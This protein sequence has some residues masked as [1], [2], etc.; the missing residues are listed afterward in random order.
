METVLRCALVCEEEKL[1]DVMLFIVDVLQRQA[2]VA[3][4]PRGL[5]T[6]GY[7]STYLAMGFANVRAGTWSRYGIR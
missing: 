2:T 1:D 3:Q 6:K 5:N 7:S 4:D